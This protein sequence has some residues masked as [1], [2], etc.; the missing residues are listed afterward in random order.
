[1]CRPCRNRHVGNAVAAAGSIRHD[2]AR[3]AAGPPR[4]GYRSGGRRLAE[5]F[6]EDGSISIKSK[7]ILALLLVSAVSAFATGWLGYRSGRDNLTERIEAQLESLREMTAEQLELFIESRRAHVRTLGADRMFIEATDRLDAAADSIADSGRLDAPRRALRA[8]LQANPPAAPEGGG[9]PVIDAYL[10]DRPSGT[11]LQYHYIVANP[12]PAERRS[13][14][15]DAGD[16]SRYSLTHSAYHET[17]AGVAEAFDYR[18]LLLI[19][20]DGNVVYSVEKEIDFATN[21]VDGPF[22]DSGLARAFRAARDALRSL[23]DVPMLRGFADDDERLRRFLDDARLE[24]FAAG[25]RMLHQR[26]FG[27]SLYLIVD[28]EAKVER[29]GARTGRTREMFE[30]GRG[31]FFGEIAMFTGAASP[32]SVIARDDVRVLRLQRAAV[33]ALVAHRPTLNAEIGRVMDA[34]R[35]AVAGRPEPVE[36]EAAVLDL[37]KDEGGE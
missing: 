20:P 21:L 10:P 32:Y 31:D 33:D 28:G 19:D 1:M 11:Y 26:R 2:R 7:I 17:L 13:A 3:S 14:L 12:E 37:G 23:S 15:A 35:R 30:L 18:D 24:V 4:A 9:E 8:Y 22:S 34:R 6:R 5:S 27:S 25:E 29:R 36:Q 16:G